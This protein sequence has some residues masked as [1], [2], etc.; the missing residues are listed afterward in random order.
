[1]SDSNKNTIFGDILKTLPCKEK[2][3]ASR[4]VFASHCQH[5]KKAIFYNTVLPASKKIPGRR[6]PY[7]A[8]T[9]NHDKG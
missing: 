8:K 2:A 3:F 5:R 9:T 7:P 4:P 6:A 1:M